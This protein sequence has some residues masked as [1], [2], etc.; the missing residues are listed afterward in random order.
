MSVSRQFLGMNGQPSTHRRSFYRSKAPVLKGERVM[1]S[2]TK[3]LGGAAGVAALATAAPAAAQYYGY[4]PYGY[5]AASTNMAA[6]RC[7]AAVQNRLH[8]RVSSGGLLGAIFGINTAT[9]GRVLSVTQVVPRR[10]TIR[11][12][13]LATSGRA[14]AYSPYGYG[15]YGAVGYAYQP[16]LSFRCSVDYRGFIRDVDINRR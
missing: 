10:N 6:Q 3:I 16:D 7:A 9:N 2:L 4:S 12:S 1:T 14:Y 13:G 5:S 11:V 15:A 8:T